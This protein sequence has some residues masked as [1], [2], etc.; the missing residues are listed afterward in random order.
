MIFDREI[1][2][3]GVDKYQ[4]LK[5]SHVMVVGLGG[6]GSYTVEALARS[7]VEE[8]SIIDFDTV[9]DTNINRQL[10]ALHSTIGR[11]KVDVVEDRLLDINPNI[12]V[13]KYNMFV[14]NNTIKDIDFSNVSYICDAIDNVNAKILLIQKSKELNIPIIS[15][16]GTGNKLDPTKFQIADINQTKY[17]PLAKRIRLELRKLDIKDVKVLYST[18]EP[19]KSSISEN[20]KVVPMSIS[21]VPSVAGLLIARYVILDI[22][23]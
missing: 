7:G 9:S 23:K 20:N 13:H 2:L 10:I 16:M 17:C 6:V 1:A 21:F 3:I 19:Y 11:P 4:I 18:E 12:V 22:I 14:D 8:I 5:D 15:S